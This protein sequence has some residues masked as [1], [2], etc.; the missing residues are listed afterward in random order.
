V[1][2]VACRSC[3]AQYDVTRVAAASF[4]CRCGASVANVSP[5]AVDAEIRRCGS[6]GAA[7]GPRDVACAYCTSPIVRDSRDLGLICP[8]CYASNGERSRFCTACGVA[9]RPEP[10]PAGP[11]VLPCVGCGCLMPRRDVAGTSVHECPQ[12]HGLWATGDGFDDLVRRAIDA[13]R[14]SGVATISRAEPRESRGNPVKEPVRYRKCPTCG[15]LM[16]RENFRRTSGVVVDRCSEH[17]TWLD[18]DELE[19]VAGFILAG[20]LERAEE[21]ESRARSGG[22]REH[23]GARTELERALLERWASSSEA[24]RRLPD[25]FLRLLGELFP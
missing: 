4:D 19:Q 2:L 8:E 11:Q 24:K 13:R 17:G 7:V 23:G 16:R 6:C 25:T 9:F 3:S 18:A 1:R 14:R 20:G 12:C 5:R 21:A 22:R 10:V 15:S